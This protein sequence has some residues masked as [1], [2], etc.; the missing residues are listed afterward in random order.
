MSGLTPAAQP[1]TWGSGAT[2]FGALPPRGRSKASRPAWAASSSFAAPSL[3]CGVALRPVR[4]SCAGGAV[5]AEGRRPRRVRIERGIYRRPTGVLEVGYRDE[6]GRLRWRTVD[7]GI[8]AARRLRDDLS[9]RRARGESIAP[10][11]KL[12]FGEA[13]AP[14]LEGPVVDLR[15]TTQ[16]KYRC[17]V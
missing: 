12:R 15:E 10:K 6:A 8:L 9:A 16:A 7:G 2:A 13:A 4:S 5:M 17:I 14:W 11:P 1:S 3:I